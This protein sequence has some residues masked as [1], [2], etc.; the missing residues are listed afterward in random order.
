MPQLYFYISLLLISSQ[1]R[2]NGNRLE[3]LSF[4]QLFKEYSEPRR[5]PASQKIPVNG[6]FVEGNEYLHKTPTQARQNRNSKTVL[7]YNL[8][9]ILTVALV[10]V[11]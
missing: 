5:M 6:V 11:P 1:I 3:H 8:G 4:C 10:Q 2:C 9:F 7:G